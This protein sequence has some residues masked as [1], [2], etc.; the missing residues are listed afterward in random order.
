MTR[1]ITTVA[2]KPRRSQYSAFQFGLPFIGRFVRGFWGPKAGPRTNDNENLPQMQ[3]V[4][5]CIR[6]TQINTLPGA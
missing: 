4:L 5:I 3:M 6:M 2:C 1:P